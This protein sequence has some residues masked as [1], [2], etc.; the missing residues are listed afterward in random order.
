VLRVVDGHGCNAVREEES[1]RLVLHARDDRLGQTNG[2]T[3]AVEATEV[4]VLVGA[5]PFDLDGEAIVG[6][7]GVLVL[8]K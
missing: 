2:L 7:V 5:D 3:A 8:Q 6:M 1:V 4:I